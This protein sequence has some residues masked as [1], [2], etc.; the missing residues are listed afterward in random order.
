MCFGRCV[1]TLS[2]TFERSRTVSEG[3]HDEVDSVQLY[4]WGVVI[5]AMC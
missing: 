1:L 5:Q 2:G 4:Y 3:G